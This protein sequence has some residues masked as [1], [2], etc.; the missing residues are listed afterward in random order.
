MN[1]RVFD[2]FCADPVAFCTASRK[3]SNAELR[4][5]GKYTPFSLKVHTP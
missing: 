3:K 4:E 1:E 2:G 5:M